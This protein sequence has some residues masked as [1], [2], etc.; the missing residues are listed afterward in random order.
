MT[1][2]SS[3]D[4]LLGVRKD[5]DLYDATDRSRLNQ[6]LSVSSSI[7]RTVAAQKDVITEEA[8]AGNAFFLGAGTHGRLALSRPRSRVQAGA[9]STVG[10]NALLESSSCVSGVDFQIG[11]LVQPV[12][13]AAQ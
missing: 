6:S 7:G 5:A 10:G 3:T 8:P 4:V 1:R 9:G 13:L 11:G 12:M 2:A